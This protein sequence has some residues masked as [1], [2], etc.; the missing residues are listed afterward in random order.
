MRSIK[1]KILHIHL[2]LL[3]VMT[4]SS[5]IKFIFIDSQW[6]FY[7]LLEAKRLSR[8]INLP[9]CSVK[10]VRPWNGNTLQVE[11]FHENKFLVIMRS[12]VLATCL[13]YDENSHVHNYKN[14]IT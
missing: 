11:K 1:S 12:Y 13:C 7:S 4:R 8:C 2:S 10:V 3:L 5:F 14:T 6:L 9:D